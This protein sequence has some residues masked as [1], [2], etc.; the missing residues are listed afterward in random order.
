MAERNSNLSR[1]DF[2]KTSGILG[3][4]ALLKPYVD[5]YPFMP[6]GEAQR[7]LN[8]DWRFF[9][10]GDQ[11]FGV[12]TTVIKGLYTKPDD[13]TDPD[14]PNKL[15]H[16]Y[17]DLSQQI[18]IREKRY[19]VNP[20]TALRFRVVDNTWAEVLK[21]NDTYSPFEVPNSNANYPG[22]LYVKI[23][24]FTPVM[25]MPEINVKL[26]TKPTDKDIIV[27]QGAAPEIMLVEG[28]EIVFRAPAYLGGQKT[29]TPLGRHLI[30]GL[31][32]SRHMPDRFIGV[33]FDCLVSPE[34]G[35]F[36]H[37]APWWDASKM[38]R[39]GHG[40]SGCINMLDESYATVKVNG[41]DVCIAQFIMEWASTNY[42]KYDVTKVED[43]QVDWNSQDA[44][45]RI[46]VHIVQTIDD[47]VNSQRLDPSR[48]FNE[49][50]K[51]YKTFDPTFSPIIP[52]IN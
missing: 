2:I 51:K 21:Q 52:V 17:G 20:G 38:K 5:I 42:P 33:P 46:P 50:I 25:P 15:V 34:K 41:I 45:N 14:I 19:M 12:A 47:L 31:Y 44:K 9:K 43:V 13:S 1:R 7:Q 35:I 30:S 18:H 39:G 40:S 48:N 37:G 36:I 32:V 10:P 23:K 3:A 29:P 4:A 26:D 28:N 16:N 22:Q 6:R 27:L 11:A 49:V 24:D 8:P